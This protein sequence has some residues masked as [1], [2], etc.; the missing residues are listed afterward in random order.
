MDTQKDQNQVDLKER[1][2]YAAF[3][4]LMFMRQKCS[5]NFVIG[6]RLDFSRYKCNLSQNILQIKIKLDFCRS[7]TQSLSEYFADKTWNL[8]FF[9]QI[10]NAISDESCAEAD[11]TGLSC[12]RHF[13]TIKFEHKAY[14]N[15]LDR[16][17]QNIQKVLDC[18]AHSKL[19]V[20]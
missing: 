1:T 8:S 14:I 3:C 19:L 16:A 17:H 2:Q 13:V 5:F 6:K 9:L 12:I 20:F 11:P 15:T 10:W 4:I 18:L 7:G